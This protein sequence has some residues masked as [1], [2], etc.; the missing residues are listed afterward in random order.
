MSF[1]NWP[2]STLTLKTPLQP[3]W[4]PTRVSS[5]T[6]TGR[7]L[8]GN[9]RLIEGGRPG[10]SR[11]YPT[12]GAPLAA[13]YHAANKNDCT[14]L[15]HLLDH[16]KHKLGPLHTHGG[17][18]A[19]KGCDTEACSELRSRE[20]SSQTCVQKARFGAVNRQEKKADAARRGSDS[21]DS[22]RPAWGQADHGRTCCCQ[23][24]PET[25]AES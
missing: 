19:D 3:I 25:A 2:G 22:P 5:K 7:R 16:A 10:R 8:W 1:M 13:C 15:S 12:N 24:R 6:F 18:L 11:S 21:S 14:T 4:L 17:L 9:A 23:D 20:Q